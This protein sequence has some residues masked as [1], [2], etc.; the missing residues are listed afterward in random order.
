MITVYHSS[1]SRSVRVLWLAEEIGLAYQLKTV[2]MFSAEMQHPEFLAVHPQGKVP[3]I[4]DDGFILWET[5]AIFDYLVTKYSD[6]SLIPSRDTELG[7]KAVQWIHFSE[8]SLAVTMG[9]IAAHSA[10]LPASRR[11]PA[12]VERG[13][14]LAPQI[15][16]IV[17]QSLSGQPFILG[18]DFSAAD[19]MLA[20][21][22]NIARHLNFVNQST[23]NCL[24]YCQ[25]LEQRA[26]YQRA[27]DK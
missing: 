18:K 16:N 15:I 17:E 20:F 14:E 22:L 2:E 27:C 13:H 10:Y 7:A 1:L 26:A 25:R 21:G 23:P 12:L 6:G 24:A 8:G 11:I 3:A 4:D 5:A 19:I 9:E